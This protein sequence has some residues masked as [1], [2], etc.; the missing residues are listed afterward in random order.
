M[1]LLAAANPGYVVKAQRLARPALARRVGSVLY[2]FQCRAL[3][4]LPTWDI[5][6]TPKVFP[7]SM[8]ALLELR[9]AGDLIDLEFLLACQRNG[10]PLL[11]VP[12]VASGRRGGVS[13]T[14]LATAWKLYTGAMR[15]LHGR[16][17]LPPRASSG[18]G[19]P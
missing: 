15:M 8:P 19:A 7:R 16:S 9:E 18:P 14:G 1:V 6:G 4:G 13:T 12:V 17:D 5:N 3:F 2:N 10:Y 11:E